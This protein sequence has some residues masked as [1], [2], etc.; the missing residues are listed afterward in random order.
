M[1]SESHLP[2]QEAHPATFS[3]HIGTKHVTLEEATVSVLRL[4]ELGEVPEGNDLFLKVPGGR[5]QGL[6]N[7]QVVT[8]KNGM[9][10]YDL[11][12]SNLGGGAA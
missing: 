12:P 1:H 3:I 8:L 10:F 9:H 6:T 7:D 2:G 5:D 11:P 4:K